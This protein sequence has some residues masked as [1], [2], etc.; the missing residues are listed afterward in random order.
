MSSSQKRSSR[1][2]PSPRAH[3]RTSR[4]S[5]EGRLYAVARVDTLRPCAESWPF[6]RLPN[7]PVPF[8]PRYDYAVETLKALPYVRWREYNPE[9]TLRFHALRLRDVGMIKSTPQTI[10][11]GTDWRLLDEFCQELK[12]LTRPPRTR[13]PDGRVS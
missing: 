5:Y 8:T 6:G 4:R 11:Q 7:S 9:S 13:L 2:R 10:G 1:R 12:G 3:V